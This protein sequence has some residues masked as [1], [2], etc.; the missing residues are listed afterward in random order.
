MRPTLTLFPLLIWRCFCR[1]NRGGDSTEIRTPISSVKGWPPSQLEDG[2]IK[3]DSTFACLVVVLST[4]T[5]GRGNIP[6]LLVGLALS[7]SPNQKSFQIF[8]R[9]PTY[10]MAEIL[11]A[12][13]VL[14]YSQLILTH[15]DGLPIRA[16]FRL[17]EK[18]SFLMGLQMTFATVILT[19]LLYYFRTRRFK[20]KNTLSRISNINYA[21]D[22]EATKIKA[23]VCL[24]RCHGESN[25]GRRRDSKLQL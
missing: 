4:D 12:F 18:K 23:L 5:T 21:S 9:L 20:R 19:G 16:R 1:A 11:S 3:Q 7:R 13:E 15:V 25:P 10:I 6:T 17:A 24:W 2:T 22:A 14:L 8:L